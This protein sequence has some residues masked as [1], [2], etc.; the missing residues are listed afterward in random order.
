MYTKEDLKEFLR[1]M[2]LKPTDCIM[3]HA[4]MKAIGEVEGRGE[5]VIDAFMEYFEEGLFMMPT[6]TW[7]Q[8]NDKNPRFDPKTEPSCVGILPDLFRSR[9]G[10]VRSL[11][12][13]HS[14]AV[15]G[16][17][18]EYE[19]TAEAYIAGEENCTS[20]CPPGGCWDRLRTVNAKILM[21]GCTHIKNTFIHS[22]EECFDVPERLSEEPRALQIKMPDGTWKDVAVKHHHNVVTPFISGNFD[23]M[24]QAFYDTGAAWDVKFGDAAC[25][26][27]DANKI[28]EV[29]GRILEKEI[30]CLIDRE[31]LPAEWWQA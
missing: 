16:K 21:I 20:P 13:T 2:G 25:M 10:V 9:P 18:T 14:M 28:Y 7:S 31:T 11:H 3:V 4:S 5:T 26:L 6:H 27:C 12:P 23:K 17:G 15:Y 29:T 22:V 19:I 8:I 24:R 1:E 30:N